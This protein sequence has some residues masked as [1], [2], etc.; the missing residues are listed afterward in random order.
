[1][2]SLLPDTIAQ[3]T[4]LTLLL[5]LTFSLLASLAI[6]YGDRADALARLGG[7]QIIE[8]IVATTLL[9]E[10]TRP[11]ERERAIQAINGPTLRVSWGPASLLPERAI[12]DWRVRLVQRSL[13]AQFGA[14]PAGRLRVAYAEAPDA[15]DPMALPG[16]TSARMEDMRIRMRTMMGGASGG[17]MGAGPGAMMGS[18]LVGRSLRVSFQLG[19]GTWLNF[20]A[21]T[22]V[23]APFWSLRLV[24]SITV[25]ALT[26][27]LLSA[28]V[29][30]RLTAPLATFAQAAERLG[31]DVNAPPLSETG[32]REVRKATQAFNEMQQR[33]RQFIEDRTRMIAAISHDLRTPITRMRLRAEFVED[34][35]QQAKML[36]DLQEMEAMIASVLSFASDE[37]SAGPQEDVDLVSLVRGLCD[38]AVEMGD[39]V[40]FEA[41]GSLTM[42]CRPLALRR[43]FA[44]LIENAVKYASRAR[45][46]L[47]E[48]P[49][50]V[51]IRIDD[52]GPGIPEAEREQVFAHFYRMERSRNRETGGTG[53]GLSV[54]RSIVR[55]HGGDILLGASPEGGL[56]V[57]VVLPR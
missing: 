31:V 42:T 8:R 26:V 39:P 5:G 24:S 17:M 51:T 9:I 46:S 23:E 52:D 20:A 56:R 37:A 6:Y 14:L 18:G 34:E 44:N 54:A 41:E 55:A 57:S 11:E 32:P 35:E 45:V 33:L 29:V 43:V 2:K 38:D 4:L 19:D 30:R 12:D 53:L 48:T 25:L 40:S 27:I 49:Q 50:E 16:D 3:R 15:P 21:P 13:E 28:W 10:N 1:M 22:E 36:A 7:G 47:F